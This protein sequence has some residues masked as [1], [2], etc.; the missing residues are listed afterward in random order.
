MIQ[1][2]WSSWSL[3]PNNIN[4]NINQRESLILRCCWWDWN[5]RW[6]DTLR[7]LLVS[8]LDAQ[9]EIQHFQQIFL[10][11]VRVWSKI[12]C[13]LWDQI[14]HA[15]K[16]PSFCYIY[17]QCQTL[18]SSKNEQLPTHEVQVVFPEM[19]KRWERITQFDTQLS[20]RYI[21][22]YCP[23]FRQTCI[24]N[25]ANTESLPSNLLNGTALEYLYALDNAECYFWLSVLFENG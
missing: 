8:R 10:S 15:E 22:S 23:P 3:L 6:F 4:Q 19:C 11:H 16:S 14:K 5:W 7:F 18:T 25:G 12:M 20:C 13:T 1:N 24:V 17:F 21:L 9:N 2:I